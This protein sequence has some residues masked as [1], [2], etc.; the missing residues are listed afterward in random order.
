MW[1]F[2]KKA[3]APLYLELYRHIGSIIDG[4]TGLI[5]LPTGYFGTCFN[6]HASET[7]LRWQMKR[8][9]ADRVKRQAEI[10]R[11][12]RDPVYFKNKS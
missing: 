3:Y 6:G 5:M 7:I 2:S 12:L 11:T 10:T 4:I 8:S 9:K 1:H